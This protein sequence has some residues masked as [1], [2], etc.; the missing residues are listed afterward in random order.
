MKKQ[1]HPVSN[2]ITVTCMNCN[3]KHEIY[4]TGKSAKI[5]ICS[6]CHPFYTGEQKLVDTANKVK[7]FERRIKVAQETKILVP[8]KRANSKVTEIKSQKALTLRDMLKSI[9]EE[10]N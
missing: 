6:H 2:L 1:I 10:E 3:T 8:K 9:K 4:S 7:D 5:D